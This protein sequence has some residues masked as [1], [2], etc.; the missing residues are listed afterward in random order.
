MTRAPGSWKACPA[1]SVSRMSGI[2]RRR[3]VCRLRNVH[4]STGNDI[5]EYPPPAP[6]VAQPPLAR[7]IILLA[8][9]HLSSR[10]NRPC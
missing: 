6:L 8:D 5:G 2:L 10:E 3:L 1:L 7:T 4:R 9:L